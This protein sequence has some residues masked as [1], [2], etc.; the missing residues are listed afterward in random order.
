MKDHQC[1]ALQ[2][3]ALVDMYLDK[4]NCIKCKLCIKT[5]PVGAISDDF[6]IDNDKCTRCNACKDVCPK[7][8]IHRVKKGSEQ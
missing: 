2:C 1:D 6:V 5:C 3:N 4:T 8:T 7:K